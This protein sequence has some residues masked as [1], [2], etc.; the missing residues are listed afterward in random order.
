[1]GIATEVDTEIADDWHA[2]LAALAWEV[3]AGADEAIGDAPIN[4]Y[5][6]ATETPKPLPAKASSPPPT[7]DAGADPVA[8]AQAAAA[9]AA[10]LEAL[11]EAVRRSRV[12]VRLILAVAGWMSGY[13]RKPRLAG[14][15]ASLFRPERIVMLMR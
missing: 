3:E 4:R 13:L 1:M 14:W 12:V 15:G 6:L 10:T 5:E 11:R 8:V 7:P 9:G 2:A